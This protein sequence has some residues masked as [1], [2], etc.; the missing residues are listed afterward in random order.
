LPLWSVINKA[1]QVLPLNYR[2]IQFQ[3][4]KGKYSRRDKKFLQVPPADF[5][6]YG[7]GK[8]DGLVYD[9]FPSADPIQQGEASMT[10]CDSI[11]LAQIVSDVSI[12]LPASVRGVFVTNTGTV[13]ETPWTTIQKSD[14][15]ERRPT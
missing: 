11:R 9:G 14:L 7:L 2:A 1:A 4:L 3:D 6:A 13:I 12:P 15:A 10:T 8:L 5:T